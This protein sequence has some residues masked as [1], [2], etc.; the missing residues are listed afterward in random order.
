MTVK[1]IKHFKTNVLLKS[2]IGKDLINDDNIAI[3]ELVKNSYDA[4]SSKV[5]VIFKNLKFNDDS[6]N[7]FYSNQ[8]SKIIIQD[9]GV[10]MSDDDIENKW[11]NIAY[12]EKK[13]KK[14]EFN[15]VLAGNKGVGRFSCDSLGKYLDL[16]SR[17][18]GEDF[19]HLFIDWE[20]FEE[21]KNSRDLQDTEIQNIPIELRI[22]AEDDFEAETGFKVFDE[23]T[24]LEISKL[25]REW[26]TL[27]RNRNKKETWN[28]KRLLELKK[29]LEKLISPNQSFGEDTF[30]INL[31]APEFIDDDFGKPKHEKV[32]GEIENKIFRKLDF[33]ATSISSVISK[34]GT[35]ITTTITDKGRDIFI[36]E[37]KNVRF[38]LLNNVNIVVYFLN[39]YSKIYF[40][41]QTGI[42]SIDFGSI[43]L[44]I[45]NF[46]IPPYGEQGDDWLGLE[47]RKQQGYGRVLGTRDLVGR[48][49]IQD[50][51]NQFQI[52]SSREGLVKDSVF[53]ELT[54]K[55]KG[56][57]FF[58]FER[59][60]RFVVEGLD[61]DRLT[62]K[63]GKDDND[64]EDHD[65]KIRKFI[66][67]FEK[68]VNTE[69][70]KF[71]PKDE[72]YFE[73]QITK[74]RRILSIIDNIINVKPDNIIELY[75]NE[76]LVV[77]LVAEE[78]RK[79][80][81]KIDE[82]KENISKFSLEQIDE[83]RENLEKERRLL[84]TTFKK[85]SDISQNR[86]HPNTKKLLFEQTKELYDIDPKEAIDILI[87]EIEE[88]H[89]REDETNTS[90]RV[91]EAQNLFYK[92]QL[93]ID[94]KK[95]LLY[96]HDIGI[97]TEIIKN[98]LSV[99]GGRIQKGKTIENEL[100]KKYVE[101]ISLE[102]NKIKT[103]VNYATKANF[104]DASNSQSN[105]LVQFITE[106]IENVVSEIEKTYDNK[107]LEI[108][109][110]NENQAKFQTEFIPMEIM[111]IID[112]LTSNSI[113]AEA[114]SVEVRFE[115]ESENDISIVFKDNGQIV[116]SNKNVEKIFDFGFTT[117]SGS[118]L[119]LYHVKEIINKMNG[120][121][122]LNK[123]EKGVEFIIK[124]SK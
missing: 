67:D 31:Y 24:I 97:S 5:N 20:L 108:K 85:A 119:G 39:R 43:Y 104:N 47:R 25:R 121:I 6:Q 106:Y 15:R 1:Q 94:V 102:A 50:N 42:R 26:V 81:E 36:L 4:N 93:N 29:Y 27:E 28:N 83:L 14:I 100:L 48:I 9:F 7:K 114:K 111:M 77:E 60:E 69:K 11:L 82:I 84:E 116:I 35:T 55:D 22:I 30:S 68:T 64:D 79:T 92:S 89:K 18:K 65:A 46:R 17:K 19:V 23:G 45:N 62:R 75:I 63:K 88:S 115:Q 54:D 13:I 98:K 56:F 96:H 76:D 32:N 103:I 95:L 41:K 113:R 78:R 110:I 33:T 52:V 21:E 101:E 61:W 124:F 44:F 112:N 74:N 57:F 99:L 34:D 123:L 109:I 107:P 53:Y 80:Q 90:L 105:D 70:W 122:E 16:Y 12:S 3:L 71:S 37:E 40:T 86:L 2:I 73:D 72:I 87:A 66:S 118:G 117:T 91:V 49:E 120:G 59:L 58:T 8:S 38:P 51:K 10:G